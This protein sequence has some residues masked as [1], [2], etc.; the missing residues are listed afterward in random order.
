MNLIKTECKFWSDEIVM[1]RC[2]IC[3]NTG[4]ECNNY[5]HETKQGTG[6]ECRRQEGGKKT[7]GDAEHTSHN[8]NL[9]M[10]C[11]F[12]IGP[13]YLFCI[14]K[15]NLLTLTAKWLSV[16][17]I[18][19]R[20]KVGVVCVFGWFS[21]LTVLRSAFPLHTFLFAQDVPF[22]NDF[23]TCYSHK[24]YDNGLFTIWSFPCLGHFVNIKNITLFRP[25]LILQ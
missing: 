12:D 5:I 1:C 2:T 17:L 21:D 25:W 18:K 3:S 7:E 9:Q 20:Q 4:V 13:Y 22:S 6:G 14:I 16:T 15:G 19:M 10:N 8:I 11:C 23:I 24:M